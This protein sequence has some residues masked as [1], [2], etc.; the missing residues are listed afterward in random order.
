MTSRSETTHLS[1][2]SRVAT[3][4]DTKERN[5]FSSLVRKLCPTVM[6]V[7]KTAVLTLM[8]TFVGESEMKFVSFRTIR[9]LLCCDIKIRNDTLDPSPC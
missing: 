9:G 8:D 1:R 6:L 2:V 3:D 7:K 5:S 4:D